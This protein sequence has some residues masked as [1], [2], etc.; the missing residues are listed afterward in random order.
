MLHFSEGVNIA[1]HSL[2]YLAQHKKDGSIKAPEIAE[3]LRVSKDHL[4][5]ILQRLA[6]IGLLHSVRGPKGGFSLTKDARTISLLDVV[7]A[8]EGQ[9]K[10]P[11]CI[12]GG[13][14]CGAA[15]KF[16]GITTRLHREL[17]EA[18]A[19]LSIQDLPPME[20]RFSLF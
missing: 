8:I 15:C 1:I 4:K 18:L 16:K 14:I 17:R 3:A 2:G 6:K 9:W 7:E 13:E 11:P 10:A 19:E 20:G 12:F 5:K